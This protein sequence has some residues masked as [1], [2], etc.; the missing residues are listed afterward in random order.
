MKA[1][2]TLTISRLRQELR[3]KVADLAEWKRTLKNREEATEEK[4][5]G[6]GKCSSG[7]A[8]CMRGFR[9]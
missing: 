8:V 3:G 2:P 7:Y 9:I 1:D 4:N 5:Q 6:K